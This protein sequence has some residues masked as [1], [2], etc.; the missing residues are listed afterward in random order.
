MLYLAGPSSPFRSLSVAFSCLCASALPCLPPKCPTSFEFTS[1]GRTSK[2]LL[3]PLHLLSTLI[4]AIILL[5]FVQ[6][7]SAQEV[8]LYAGQAP[9][10]VGNWTVVGDST[11]A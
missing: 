8:V 3:R 5:G 2:L 1:E 10:R 7:A 6:S 9:V 11:A 4:F